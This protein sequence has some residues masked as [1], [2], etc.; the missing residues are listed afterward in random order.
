MFLLY[1]RGGIY[2]NLILTAAAVT[3]C[4]SRILPAKRALI[5]PDMALK[6]FEIY[7]PEVAKCRLPDSASLVR[8]ANHATKRR[9]K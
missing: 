1:F 4:Q 9:L 8:H 7:L 2:R 6:Y 5:H 3:A